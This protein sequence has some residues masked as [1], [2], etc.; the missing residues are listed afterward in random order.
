MAEQGEF[1]PHL[2]SILGNNLTDV[3]DNEYDCQAVQLA[4]AQRIINDKINHVLG[5]IHDVENS[6]TFDDSFS[7]HR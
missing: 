7:S 4:H 1:I 6:K 5:R 3:M 2:L